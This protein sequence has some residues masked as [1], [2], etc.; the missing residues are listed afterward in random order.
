VP[1]PF[2]ADFEESEAVPEDFIELIRTLGLTKVLE[3]VGAPAE[4]IRQAKDIERD[5]GADAAKELLLQFLANGEIDPVADLPPPTPR[6]RPQRGGR[7]K[8]RDA[9]DGGADDDGDMP[10]QLNLF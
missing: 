6:P 1:F 9:S 2:E 7:R 8:S 10:K 4:L 3:M 5:L